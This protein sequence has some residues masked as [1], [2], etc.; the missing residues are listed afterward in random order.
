[1]LVFD[2]KEVLYKDTPLSYEGI[3]SLI[4]FFENRGH[5]EK[6]ILTYI[7]Y[8]YGG[9]IDYK[10]RLMKTGEGKR[11]MTLDILKRANDLQKHIVD[12]RATL[13]KYKRLGEARMLS[14]YNVDTSD[15]SVYIKG[16]TQEAIIKTLVDYEQLKID[17]YQLEFDNL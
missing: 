6:A 17:A 1:M 9:L 2:F 15:N 11:R 16:E 4:G 5:L 8:G 7:E 12:S 13:E 10:K 14:L 3:Y